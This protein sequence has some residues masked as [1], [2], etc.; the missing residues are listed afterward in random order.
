MVRSALR[1][2]RLAARWRLMRRG[3]YVFQVFVAFFVLFLFFAFLVSALKTRGVSQGV[4]S[5]STSQ[6]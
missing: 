4:D 3:H 2:H 5:I 6:E 1:P